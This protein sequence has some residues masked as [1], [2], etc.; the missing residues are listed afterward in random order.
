[1][2][3]VRNGSR[4]FAEWHIVILIAADLTRFL[5]LAFGTTESGLAHITPSMD[6]ASR[7]L[8]KSTSQT[9]YSV[10]V[11][12]LRGSL[13]TALLLVFVDVMKELPATLMLRPFNFN[14]LATRA[15]GYAS[16]E[17]LEPAALWCLAIVVVGLTP[18]VLLNRQLRQAHTRQETPSHRLMPVPDLPEAAPAP[19]ASHA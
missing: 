17:M 14:T 7:T 3:A 6:E 9:L 10:H 13:L 8:G 15:Y 19:E 12:L 16:D 1:M 4:L 2:P 18:V 5:A 11:P